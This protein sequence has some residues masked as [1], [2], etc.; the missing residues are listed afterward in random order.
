MMKFSLRAIGHVGELN[1]FPVQVTVL[2]ADLHAY[3]DNMKAPWELLE[4]R[5]KYYEAVIKA[6]LE[7]IGVPLDKL[8]FVRGSTYQLERDYSLDVYRLVSMVGCVHQF[9]A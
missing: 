7:S 9:C 8:K 4:H 3:L 1:K 6:M 5:V 2:F